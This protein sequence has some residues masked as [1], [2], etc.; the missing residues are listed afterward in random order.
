MRLLQQQGDG[1]Q[2][3]R[4]IAHARAD[5]QAGKIP[6][7]RGEFLRLFVG[8]G[9]DL[10]VGQDIEVA[11]E[12]RDGGG[13]EAGPALQRGEGGQDA[14]ARFFHGAGDDQRVAESRPCGPSRAPRQQGLE[15]G[16][17]AQADVHFL[18]LFQVLGDADV[19]DADAAAI[20]AAV[21]VEVGPFQGVQ[22]GRDAG[23]D[24]NAGFRGKAFAQA[25]GDVHGGHRQAGAVDRVERLGEQPFGHGLVQAGAENGV[26]QEGL[27]GATGG[28]DLFQLGRG[29]RPFP[30]GSPL[31]GGGRSSTLA[32]GLSSCG[33][34]QEQDAHV[35]SLFQQQ[36]ADGQ[37]VAAVVPL[38]GQDQAVR[39]AVARELAG[40]KRGA[41]AGGILHQDDG[42][43][44]ALFDRRAVDLPH[45]GIEQDLHHSPVF[46]FPF[47]S[48][49]PL[50]LAGASLS[51]L[52]IWSSWLAKMPP[53]APS[54]L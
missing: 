5:Q 28:E 17:L 37:A 41:G 4:R 40:E 52:T 38:A 44:A 31:P 23:A 12:R 43:D 3:R 33:A 24:V 49:L 1:A 6:Q 50:L 39:V 36:A 18:P 25:R 51:F 54:S 10:G 9:H 22:R 30:G 21:G 7:A 20:R 32:A 42:G 13:A 8:Q 35:V 29:A 15:I 14:R 11:V 26:D 2:R 16:R 34:G 46:F 48:F 27:A 47:F 19:H 45:P 53:K